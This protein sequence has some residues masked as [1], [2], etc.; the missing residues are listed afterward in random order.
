MMT[1]MLSPQRAAI[2]VLCDVVHQ[3]LM[4]VFDDT[5]VVNSDVEADVCQPQRLAAVEPSKSDG[6]Q[7]HGAC[8]AQ[9][10]QNICAVSR[11]GD[12]DENVAWLGLH[13]NLPREAGL[14]AKVVSARREQGG[15]GCERMNVNWRMCGGK[16]TLDPVAQEVVGDS[17]RTTVSGDPKP[18]TTRSRAFDFRN[19]KIELAPIERKQCCGQ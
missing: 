4:A 7:P 18:R 6:L 17:C 1:C 9:H 5:I 13:L 19:R 10:R 15:I 2:D 16:R 12:A 11:R 14:M 8:F 3:Y